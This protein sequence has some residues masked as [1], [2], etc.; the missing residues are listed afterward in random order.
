MQEVRNNISK[1][2]GIE[3]VFG[4]SK[5]LPQIILTCRFIC[6]CVCVCVCV[7]LLSVPQNFKEYFSWETEEIYEILSNLSDNVM[8]RNIQQSSFMF[9]IKQVSLVIRCV[10]LQLWDMEQ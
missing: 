3:F 5:E 10:E 2:W 6:V 1:E 8:S 7:M 9:S 4:F